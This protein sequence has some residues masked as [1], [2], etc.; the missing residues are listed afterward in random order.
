MWPG[1]IDSWGFLKVPK[2]EIFDNSDFDDF[3]TIKSLWGGDFWVKIK[4][5]FSYLGGREIPYAYAQS[6][7]KEDFFFSLGKQFFFPRSFWDHLLASTEIFKN[8]RC[9]RYFK[10]YQKNWIPYAHAPTFMRTLSIRVR[11]WCAP[12]ACAPGTVAH[13]E[14]THQFLTRML[15]MRISFRIFQMFILYTLSMRVRNWCVHWACTSGTDA[16]TEHTNQELVR[17]LSIRIRY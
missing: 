7:F 15:S 8:F 6:N 12:W 3:Y 17:A 14:H 10:N 5:F 13:P 11:N 1:G 4:V 9:F 2:C 16:Y